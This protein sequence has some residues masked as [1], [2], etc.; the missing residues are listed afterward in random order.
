MLH[1][2]SGDLEACTA[3]FPFDK[4]FVMAYPIK[5]SI[6]LITGASQ[7][8]GRALAIAIADVSDGV[9]VHY[10]NSRGAAED[11]ARFIQDRGGRAWIVQAD[12]AEPGQAATLF[13][14]A[15]LAAG[16]DISILINNASIF[17]QGR[18]ES[19]T[20]AEFNLNMNIHVL[21]PLLLSQCMAAQK[22]GGN[23]INMLD[24]RILECDNEHAAYHISKRTLFTLTR[25]LA[26]E[27]APA[28]RVN[29]VAPGLV[30]P[31]AGEDNE[32][33]RS[34][35][36]SLPLQC[37]GRAEQVCDAVLFLLRNTFITGQII[38]VDGGRHLRGSSYEA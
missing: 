12:L 11:T 14:A 33:L 27:L 13:A 7:R 26:R 24:T 1:G 19:L 37:Y 21:A 17:E 8:L 4:L 31:P 20:A 5:S 29:G 25:M 30:L 35:C 18:P 28:I 34:R 36:H 22:C 6:A 16:T 38:Y 10:N 23:I 15:R 9:V 32:Y 2:K 3:L